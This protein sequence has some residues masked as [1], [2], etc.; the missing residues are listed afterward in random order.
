MTLPKGLP[1]GLTSY[2]ST[3]LFT[4]ESIPESL[5]TAHKI[6]AGVW[7]V[8]RV[9]GGRV[10]YCIDGPP[11]SAEVVSKGGSVLI[12][13]QVLH[14]AELLDHDSSFFIEFYRAEGRG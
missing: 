9:T 13:P 12:E 6:K 1:P 2:K 11:S 5:L 7:G 8:L 3:P 4:H 10:R 14:H